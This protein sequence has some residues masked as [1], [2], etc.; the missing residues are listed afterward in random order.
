M[1]VLHKI[2]LQM[3]AHSNYYENQDESS[4]KNDDA[5]VLY[6]V[7]GSR[8]EFQEAKKWKYARICLCWAVCCP[9]CSS[10]ALCLYM[11]MSDILPQKKKKIPEK[12]NIL[13]VSGGKINAV[14]QTAALKSQG[15]LENELEAELIQ[16]LDERSN[17]HEFCWLQLLVQKLKDSD[18]FMA[19]CGGTTGNGLRRLCRALSSCKEPWGSRR[20]P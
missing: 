13:I 1:K 15:R 7:Y 14:H 18:S 5:L 16:T 2:R 9:R 11:L 10:R 12:E 6:F 17:I 8:D 20:S 3:K 4:L 19:K